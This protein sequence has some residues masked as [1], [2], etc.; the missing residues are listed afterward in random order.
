MGFDLNTLFDVA[1][2]SEERLQFVEQCR[3]EEMSDSEF[4][5]SYCDEENNE[6]TWYPSES[7][8]EEWKQGKEKRNEYK[9]LST[10]GH[11]LHQLVDL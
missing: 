8:I 9:E 4:T 7:A 2:L 6:R 3:K 10:Q 11:C 5:G 1:G